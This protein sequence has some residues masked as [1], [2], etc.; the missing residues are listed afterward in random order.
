MDELEEVNLVGGSMPFQT[1]EDWTKLYRY[2]ESNGIGNFI[3]RN[4]I[5]VLMLFFIMG[6][7]SFIL[8]MVDWS[9]LLQCHEIGNCGS[10]TEFLISHESW[11]VWNIFVYGNLVVS[12]FHCVV[13]FVQTIQQIGG[14]MWI[15]NYLA[16]NLRLYTEDVQTMTWP[17]LVGQICEYHGFTKS[18]YPITTQKILKLDHLVHGLVRNNVIH[19]RRLPFTRFH[20]WI[21][22]ILLHNA[23][24]ITVG[25]FRK[26]C[27]QLG[28]LSVFL[29]PFIFISTLI[30]F[31]IRHSEEIHTKKNYAGPRGWTFYAKILFKKYNEFPHEFEI[32]MIES[33]RHANN[34]VAQF[35]SPMSQTCSKFISFIAVGL[36]T[37]LSALGLF[38]ENILLSVTL[39]GRNLLFY[40]VLFSAI[41][42][43]SQGFTLDPNNIPHKPVEKMEELVKCIQYFPTEWEG[44]VHTF[45]VQKAIYG[46]YKLRFFNFVVESWGVLTA[47]YFLLKVLPENADNIVN[48]I[49]SECTRY[50]GSWAYRPAIQAMGADQWATVS[51]DRSLNRGI[52]R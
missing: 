22:R 24:L 1:D 40:T 7:S 46:L 5:N 8:C 13:S 26:S 38:D 31:A 16:T 21:L 3:L 51:S 44:K 48:H 4:V 15:R 47:P 10:F 42:A 18:V 33:I 19:M 14:A 23:D 39:G 6:F 27:K 34:Y 25:T 2:Y 28:I 41:L 50:E 30:Y 52:M 29:T 36:L 43:L 17:E 9:Q 20:G 11:S 32:R 49:Q 12:I 35:P 45:E 37:V